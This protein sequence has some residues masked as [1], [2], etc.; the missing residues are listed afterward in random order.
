M[1]RANASVAFFGKCQ[2]GW[3]VS[4][5]NTGHC[6]FVVLS[7]SLVSWAGISFMFLPLS[8]EAHQ[9]CEPWMC[10]LSWETFVGGRYNLMLLH[11]QGAVLQIA[12]LSTTLPGYHPFPGVIKVEIHQRCIL[13]F[14]MWL[15]S[16]NIY[17]QTS[18]CTVCLCM[19]PPVDL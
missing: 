2:A 6:P 13:F 4:V 11:A 19:E 3:T 8:W 12:S 15:K 7:T 14:I 18:I 10:H 16:T 17:H 5:V 9:S 1:N